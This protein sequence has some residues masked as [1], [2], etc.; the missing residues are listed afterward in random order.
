MTQLPAPTLAQ[1][2]AA[3]EGLEQRGESIWR[4]LGGF[5]GNAKP[6]VPKHVVEASLNA[7]L[8]AS[9]V[10]AY[11]PALTGYADHIGGSANWSAAFNADAG[12]S[13]KTSDGEVSPRLIL[14]GRMD[15]P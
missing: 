13:A 5:D 6:P 7:N 8:P 4:H 9:K 15:C 1:V 12:D 14:N 3:I 10:L 11:V 2:E